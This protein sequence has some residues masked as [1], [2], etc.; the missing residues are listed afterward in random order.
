VVPRAR[1]LQRG[2]EILHEVDAIGTLNG[3]RRALPRRQR[4]PPRNPE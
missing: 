3:V 2:D 4:M 1:A